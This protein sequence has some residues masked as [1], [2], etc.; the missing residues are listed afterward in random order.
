VITQCCTYDL[1]LRVWGQPSQTNQD[2][3]GGLLTQPDDKFAKVLVG[4]QYDSAA[5]ACGAKHG[6]I[7]CIWL[8]FRYSGAL[9]AIIP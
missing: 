7:E 3:A 9:M 1:G 5:L 8:V 4:R 2:N 6:V